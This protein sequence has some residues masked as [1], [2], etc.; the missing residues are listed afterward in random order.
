MS[1]KR[2]ERWAFLFAHEGKAMAQTITIQ[3][4]LD[5]AQTGAAV[6]GLKRKI[7]NALDGVNV[8]RITSSFQQVRKSALDAGDSIDKLR[9]AA[10]G[11]SVAFGVLAGVGIAAGLQQI[12][13]TAL[14]AAF[15]L[16]K[17][18]QT[19]IALTGSTDAANKKL[20]ELRQLSQSPGVTTSFAV[21]LFNQLKAL[22]TIAEPTINKIIQSIGKLNAVFS[23]DSPKDFGRNLTQI[24][25]QG[26]E[27]ADIKEAIG[28]VPIFEQIL[29]QA[30]GTKDADELRKLKESG[31]LTMDAFLTGISSAI[32]NDPRFANIQESLGSKFDRLRDR[33]NTALEPLGKA[34]SDV[35]LP[36][37]DDLAAF[38]EKYGP[39]A[40]RAF[41]DSK[42]VARQEDE[43]ER[44]RRDSF[45]KTF[46]TQT[47]GL[48]R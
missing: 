23:I 2:A 17:T 24:F 27:R 20:A 15:N 31:K 12:A 38:T 46:A 34:L 13:S 7:G 41:S 44:S 26:F 28:P 43:Q 9:T 45:Y 8:S 14:T 25:S 35:L 18:R 33:V 48:A 10:R 40:V 5:T 47:C 16:D 19:L 6:D 32:D 11:L 36:L 30:F 37:F 4:K 29:E 1:A 21:D 3:V 42:T 39:I 22:N